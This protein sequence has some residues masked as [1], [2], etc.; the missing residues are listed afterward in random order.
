M[1]RRG[2]SLE[3]EGGE[4]KIGILGKLDRRPGGRVDSGFGIEGFRHGFL[5]AGKNGER[6]FQCWVFIIFRDGESKVNES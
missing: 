2:G 6:L 1:R 5:A 4:R 3:E